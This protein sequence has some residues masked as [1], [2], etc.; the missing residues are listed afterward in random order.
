MSSRKD[1]SFHSD[2]EFI[3][4]ITMNKYDKTLDYYRGCIHTHW[5]HVWDLIV[6]TPSLPTV[7]FTDVRFNT[8]Y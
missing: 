7:E 4:Q 6:E 1:G 8:S 3:H 5:T 2:S